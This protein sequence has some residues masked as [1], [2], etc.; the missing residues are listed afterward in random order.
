LIAVFESASAEVPLQC[1]AEVI[2]PNGHAEFA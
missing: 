2:R 1:D